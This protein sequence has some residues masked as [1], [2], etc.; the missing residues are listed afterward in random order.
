LTISDKEN[1]IDRIVPLILSGRTRIASDID[2]VIADWFRPFMEAANSHLG[3]N[4]DYEDAWSHNMAEV[5]NV[6]EARINELLEATGAMRNLRS[7]SCIDDALKSI[8]LLRQH[9]LF[10]IITSRSDSHHQDTVAYLEEVSK[11]LDLHY[12]IGAN[13]PYVEDH[14]RKSKEQIAEQIG[15]FCLIEDNPAE[16]IAWKSNIVVPLCF[17]QPWNASLSEEFPRLEWSDLLEIFLSREVLDALQR[18]A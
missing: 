8:E 18:H 7:L 6:S 3:V 4:L 14:G 15:A 9:Y 1:L 16:F 13:N 12:G 11:G 10:S 5:F 2:G 17:A